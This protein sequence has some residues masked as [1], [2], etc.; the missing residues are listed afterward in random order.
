MKIHIRQV[1]LEGLEL[2]ESLSSEWI[3]L[4][5][6]DNVRF[7]TPVDIK[8]KVTRADDEAFVQIKANSRYE[9]F[10]YRCLKDI[11]NDWA[12]NFTLSFDVDK[13]AEF[14]DVSEDVRQELILN[15]PTRI[16]CQ[17]N[18]KGLCIDCGVN[19]NTET[20]HCALSGQKLVVSPDA[21]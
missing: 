16:L 15:L 18:C 9:S 4:T 12:T 1:R 6:K 3:G 14:I 21:C 7:I 17:A 20:C 8:A 2:E 19:L 10:C 13:Q 5:R 11:K